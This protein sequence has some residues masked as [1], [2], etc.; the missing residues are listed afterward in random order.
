MRGVR[1]A[2]VV[3]ATLALS[4]LA[5]TEL[6]GRAG[7][8]RENLVLH[9][10]AEP[11]AVTGG[12]LNGL[13]FA[14]AWRLR[15]DSGRFGGLSGLVVDGEGIVAVVDQGEILTARLRRNGNSLDIRDAALRALHTADGRQ[16]NKRGGDA[17]GLARIGDRLFVTFERDHRIAQ[18]GRDG[19]IGSV[20]RL[21]R[22]AEE[23]DA[24]GGLEGLAAVDGGLLAIAETPGE[25]GF[26]VLALSPGGNLLARGRLPRLSRHL[27]TGADV[28]PDGRLY[29]VLRDF[30]VLTG[31]SI[32]VQSYA[33][34][35]TPPM[36]VPDSVRTL[37]AFEQESGIDNMEAISLWR[38]AEG[39]LRLWL[40]ADDNFNL[41][42]RTL[43]IEFL[44][45]EDL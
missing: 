37:A 23:L 7:E 34:A 10:T 27:V 11:V 9:V 3:L 25:G 31:V 43:L 30:S 39:R 19:R 18:V 12:V 17:E 45:A 33:L 20:T 35:G 5:S 21:G 6:T 1:P 24:N 15:A 28:A 40:L 29:V 36:P 13:T 16:F 41:L 38:D 32:R 26:D 22:L 14:G 4:V 8:R 44:V 2:L 42:Q